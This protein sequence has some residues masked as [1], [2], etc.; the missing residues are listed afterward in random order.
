MKADLCTQVKP[1]GSLGYPTSV[2]LL[3]TSG[4]SIGLGVEAAIFIFMTILLEF[5]AKI[6]LPIEAFV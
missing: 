2:V 4:N 1:T 5:L 3:V 6:T